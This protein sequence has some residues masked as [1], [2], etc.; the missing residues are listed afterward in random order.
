MLL[1]GT[2]ESLDSRIRVQPSKD[3]WTRQRA[4][5]WAYFKAEKPLYRTRESTGTRESKGGESTSPKGW[6]RSSTNA[7]S[8]VRLSVR[9]PIHIKLVPSVCVFVCLSG[10]LAEPFE[11]PSTKTSFRFLFDVQSTSSVPC[12]YNFHGYGISE[13]NFFTITIVPTFSCVTPQQAYLAE[14]LPCLTFLSFFLSS[15]MRQTIFHL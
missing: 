8:S 11:I 14:L 4:V 3:L 7:L 15:N 5:T 12:S 2:R 13:K 6:T 9:P 1:I 10:C